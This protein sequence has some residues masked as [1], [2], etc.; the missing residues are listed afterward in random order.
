MPLITDSVGRVLGQRYRLVS[1]LGSGA[2]AHVFL[3]QDIT[4]R[5]PVAVKVL[6]PGL[7]R[8]AAFL[9]RFGAEARAAASL[10]NP[11]VLRVF[12][13]GEDDGPYLVLEYLG[14]GSL[15][16]L[17]DRKVR[18]THAQAARLGRE[19]ADGLAYAHARGLVHRDIKPAN[20]LF[21]EEG[22]V[23]IA[24]FGVARALAEAAWTE[25]AGA[26]I[27]TARYAS[28]EQAE[29]RPVNGRADVY[30][31]ALVLYETLSGVVPFSSDTTV[32]TLMARVG[33]PLPSHPALGPLEPVLARAAFPDHSRRL[34]AQGLSSALVA[35]SSTLPEPEPLPVI[36]SAANGGGAAAALR[37]GPGEVFDIEAI[38][39]APYGDTVH[40]DAP[41]TAVL[42][43]ASGLAVAAGGGVAAG[44]VAGG[45]AAVDDTDVAG[46]PTRVEQQSHTVVVPPT[47]PAVA[48]DTGEG[49]RRRRWPWI[50]GLVVVLALVAGLI[51][52]AVETKV[53][54]PSHK[55][56]ALTGLTEAQA[57]HELSA[58]HLEMAVGT[59][60]YS[61][62]HPA[63]DVVSQNP[64]SGTMLKE[65]S[66]VNVT[67]S[68]GLP[69]VAVPS[70]TGLDCPSALRVLSASHLVGQ[71]PPA[72]AAYS[73]TVPDGQV[74]NWS[75]DNKLNAKSA[76]FGSTVLIAISK[77]LP[78]VTV[79]TVSGTGSTYDSAAQAL[80][81]AGVTPARGQQYSTSVPQGEVIG[82]DPA[83]GTSVP[84]GSTVTVIVSEGP[85]F[86]TV[87]DVSGDSVSKA[88][89]QLQKAG[90]TPGQVFGPSGSS[91]FATDPAIGSSVQQGTTV[92]LYIGG[93][94]AGGG[95]HGG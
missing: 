70:L 44:S 16:D 48:G 78:P 24:D 32:A 26:M 51:A 6:Q 64:A 18:L 35:L 79:P 54:T 12:D 90:L 41:E 95:G 7:S 11:H 86:V 47:P 81:Q 38:G 93:A 37:A 89:S 69:P 66:T 88:E 92:N 83:T 34:D 60:V 42:G 5:R 80:Q 75:Y 46:A 45:V 62:V 13:W 74:I 40:R 52:A 3:A 65:G 82:T 87:P 17:L 94:G 2:S 27:G 4:L 72:A 91:V 39:A 20:L 15:R 53:F 73:T 9:K 22:R 29:G 14:G 56:P 59:P 77:G 8:D 67:P 10:N 30:S 25:P 71:C 33:A 28:P 19:V 31:L 23:R 36:P 43:A 49:R 55:V 76:P 57:R 58:K 63:G 21:D 1:A 84:H 85:P 68:K 50:V 61:L